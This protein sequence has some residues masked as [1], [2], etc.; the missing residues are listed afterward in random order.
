MTSPVLLRILE[1]PSPCRRRVRLG[2]P[3]EGLRGNSGPLWVSSTLK[4]LRP[5]DDV[6][7]RRAGNFELECVGQFHFAH[8]TTK[9]DGHLAPIG[10]EE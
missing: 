3:T 9:Y 5:T 10:H 8:R 7:V 6:A 1:R 4:S 2:E